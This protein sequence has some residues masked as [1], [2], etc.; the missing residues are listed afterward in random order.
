[1]ARDQD[2]IALSQDPARSVVRDGFVARDVS[3]AVG[4]VGPR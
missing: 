1:M 4:L 3:G 2:Q